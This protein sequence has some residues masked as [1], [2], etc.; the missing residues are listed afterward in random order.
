MNFIDNVALLVRDGLEHGVPPHEI[1]A[2]LEIIKL[3]L[4]A[5]TFVP[6]PEQAVTPVILKPNGGRA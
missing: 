1:M 3:D 4:A 5:K 6:Q 2:A